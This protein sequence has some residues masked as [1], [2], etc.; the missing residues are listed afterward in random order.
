M[1]L[2]EEGLVKFECHLKP[3]PVKY[4]VKNDAQRGFISIFENV[5]IQINRKA[6]QVGQHGGAGTSFRGQ[7]VSGGGLIGDF[8]QQAIEIGFVDGVL[9]SY[10]LHG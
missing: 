7:A 3:Q 4:L 6:V 9:G 1:K 8:D 10:V 2:E 5:E